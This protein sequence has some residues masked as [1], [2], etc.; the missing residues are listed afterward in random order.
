MGANE[1]AARLR[2]TYNSTYSFTVTEIAT[3]YTVRVPELQQRRC[4]EWRDCCPI[5]NGD[6]STAF[7]VDPLTGRWFCH[8]QC[9]CGGDIIDLER[10][11]TGADFPAARD[12]V[13]AIVGRPV[14]ASSRLSHSELIALQHAQIAEE[15]ERRDSWDLARMLIDCQK[16]VLAEMGPFDPARRGPTQMI[17]ALRRDPVCE[18]RR[19]RKLYPKQCAGLIRAGRDERARYLRGWKN[20]FTAEVSDAA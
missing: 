11:I 18:L 1:R 7:S 6:N 14:P 5:H 10:A 17:E 19:Y 2:P 13:L 12:A 9:N 4:S 3:Y 16:R 8:S 20:F 15:Q